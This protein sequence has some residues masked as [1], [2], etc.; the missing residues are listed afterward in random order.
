MELATDL[1]QVLGDRLR[2]QQVILN[3]VMDSI[4]AMTIVTDRSRDLLI[5]SCQYESDK[6]LVAVKDAGLGCNPKVSIIF[7]RLSLRQDR[8]G[9]YGV[10]N[11]PFQQR[12]SRRAAM[13][14]PE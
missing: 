7:S 5:R 2:L 10:G 14:Y 13:G 6:V 12:E 1:P 8:K 4:E 3:L 9:E 11:Q